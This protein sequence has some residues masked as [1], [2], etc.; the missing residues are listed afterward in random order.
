MY[1]TVK[2]KRRKTMSEDVK[3]FTQADLDALTAEHTKAMKELEERLKGET[4]RKVDAAI[5]KT[6]AEAEE[7][8]K[9]ANLSELEKA[10]KE[11]S[12]FK[13]KYEA[14]AEKTAL[15]AQK[16]EARKLMN[17]LGVDEKCLDFVFIPKDIEGTKARMQAFKGYV[18]D[19]KKTT[20]ENN[21]Q[22][23]TPKAGDA[24]KQKDAF[25]LG[26]DS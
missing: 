1:R 8:A 20:F 26:F 22:S 10:Q 14:E 15:T 21:V 5:K 2:L 23:T 16:E 7:A 19:V 12:D 3:T 11:A 13:A 17:E 6:Q 9:N 24:P 4:A 25:E 18:D